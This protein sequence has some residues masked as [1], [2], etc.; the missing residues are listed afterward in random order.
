MLRDSEGNPI[1]NAQKAIDQILLN[2]YYQKFKRENQSSQLFII[3]VGFNPF[4]EHNIISE[5]LIK[6]YRG[7]DL[8]YGEQD[9]WEELKI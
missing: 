3:G 7:N 6:K 8:P 5:V 1:S 9:S 4:D 2:K